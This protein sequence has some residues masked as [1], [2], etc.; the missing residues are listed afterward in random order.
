[1]IIFKKPDDISAFL[2]KKNLQGLSTGFV[3]T[4]GALHTGHIYLLQECRRENDCSIVSIFVNPTQFNN[5]EDFEKYPI[6][7]EQDI[8]MLEAS[9]C[10]VLFLPGRN[11]IYPPGYSAEYYELGRMETILEGEFR[12]GHYQGVC[13][14]VDRLLDIIKPSKMYLGLKDYQQ[15]IVLSRMATSK[16]I[17]VL[18]RLCETVREPDGLAKS[19][20]NMRLSPAARETAAYIYQ[21]LNNIKH[22]FGKVNQQELIRSGIAMLQDQGFQ[23]DYLSIADAK[24]LNPATEKQPASE[25][26]VLIAATIG[27]VRLIDNLL[28]G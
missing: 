25:L 19:S 18:L 22:S 20:R 3:P 26:V 2:E 28:L 15:C 7:V 12:P 24:T 16:S 5:K 1:M 23:V 27:G 14:V 17:P 9:G 6:T 10:D 4:M 11:E 13:Q 21:V 8:Y